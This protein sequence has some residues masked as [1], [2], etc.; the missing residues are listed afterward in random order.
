MQKPRLRFFTEVAKWFSI[1]QP[2]WRM[3]VVTDKR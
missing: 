2:G 3:E 1:D